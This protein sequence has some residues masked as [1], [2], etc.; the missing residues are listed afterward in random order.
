MDFQSSK[1]SSLQ[2]EKWRAKSLE[3]ARLGMVVLEK[4]DG[5][6][7]WIVDWVSK[8]KTLGAF[9]ATA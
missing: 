2:N 7:N 5:N 6:I 8:M 3:I 4:F 1:S 9:D